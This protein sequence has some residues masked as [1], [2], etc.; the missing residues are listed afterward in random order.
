MRFSMVLEDDLA[1]ELCNFKKQSNYDVK[2]IE[3]I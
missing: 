3:Q 1:Q 2:T